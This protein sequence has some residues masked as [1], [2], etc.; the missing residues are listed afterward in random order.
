MTLTI[1]TFEDRTL[2]TLDWGG[3][4]AWVARE[5]G[6]ITG[7]AARGQRLVKKIRGPWQ[8]ELI[9][10]VDYLYMLRGHWIRKS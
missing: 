2:H 9:E 8:S 6:A 10:A 3:Q 5:I 4:P 1:H 7:Y